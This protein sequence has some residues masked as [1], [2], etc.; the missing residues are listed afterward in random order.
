ML[1]FLFNNSSNNLEHWVKFFKFSRLIF[2]SN[3]SLKSFFRNKD[4]IKDIKFALPHLSPSP[5][6]VPWIC[7]TPAWTAAKLFAT[8][9]SV[10]L[11]A[12]I[13]KFSPGICFV[14]SDTILDTSCGRVPPLV[15]HKTIHLAPWSYAAF[16]HFNA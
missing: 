13:P 7:L 11:W 2:N 10:S 3:F 12:W 14:I 5:L 6:M 8:A 15:S 1:G 16:K 4:G 9:F